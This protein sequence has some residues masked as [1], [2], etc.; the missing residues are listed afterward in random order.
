MRNKFFGAIATV[1]T[2][3]FSLLFGSM[4]TLGLL[5]APILFRTVTSRDLA[6]RVFGNILSLWFWV[7]LVCTLSLVATA[8]FTVATVRENR[9]IL[10][11][12]LA[13]LVPMTVI[14]TWFGFV[15]A[16]MSQI[17][18]SLT[19]PIEEY[20]LTENPRLEF[21]G[22]HKLSTQLMTW[23]LGLSLLWFGLTIWTLTAYVKR[24]SAAKPEAVPQVEREVVATR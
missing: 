12:R 16:R 21:D 5:V 19:R 13:L 4:A 17:Q 1:E 6:G 15:M 3:A 18:A 22:L 14:V 11:G 7:A 9:R 24:A 10:A 20:S 23:N 2:L 8:I